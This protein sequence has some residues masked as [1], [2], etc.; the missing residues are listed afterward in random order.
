MKQEGFSEVEAWLQGHQNNEVSQSTTGHTAPTVIF[1][2]ESWAT[3]SISTVS[4]AYSGHCTGCEIPLFVLKICK[5]CCMP[6]PRA[7]GQA[8]WAS[9][10]LMAGFRRSDISQGRD[11]CEELGCCVGHG[12]FPLAALTF[13]FFFP[14]AKEKK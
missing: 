12:I 11:K 4:L 6:V 13:F 8:V 5:L 9:S 3:S 2:P 10:E 14:D 7:P 1:L